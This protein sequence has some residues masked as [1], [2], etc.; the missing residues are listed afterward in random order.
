MS[1][2]KLGKGLKTK[3]T[4]AGGHCGY[5]FVFPMDSFQDRRVKII[6]QTCE[7]VRFCTLQPQ[8]VA[9]PTRSQED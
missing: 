1:K 2:E 3:T 4:T 8:A 7:D 6:Q 9:L 5:L